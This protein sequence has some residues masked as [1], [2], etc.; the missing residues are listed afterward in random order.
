ML[1]L[2][3]HASTVKDAQSENRYKWHDKM[4]GAHVNTIHYARPSHFR[5]ITK[6]DGA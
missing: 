3:E 2:R 5:E 1:L 4:I 6:P